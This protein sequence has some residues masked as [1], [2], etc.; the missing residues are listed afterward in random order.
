MLKILISSVAVFL[1]VSTQAKEVSGHMESFTVSNGTCTADIELKWTQS[2]LIV[3]ER[4]YVCGKAQTRLPKMT[5]KFEPDG[6]LTL[7]G[8]K[9][10]GGSVPGFI[11]FSSWAESKSF[12]KVM[13][14]YSNGYQE[15]YSTAD[16]TFEFYGGEVF[17][18]NVVVDRSTEPTSDAHQP[19]SAPKRT[20]SVN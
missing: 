13:M 4:L 16:T 5:Y 11:K 14:V 2:E 6:D 20:G 17:K 10:N 12:P 3:A 15:R 1:S 19:T 9:L 7:N 18:R 8:E